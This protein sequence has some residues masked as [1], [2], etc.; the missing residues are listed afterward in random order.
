MS[1]ICL[2]TCAALDFR[3]VMPNSMQHKTCR[4]RNTNPLQ[5]SYQLPSATLASALNGC[6]NGAAVPEGHVFHIMRHPDWT[7]SRGPYPPGNQSKDIDGSS[8]RKGRPQVLVPA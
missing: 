2:V 8:A 4:P 1:V 5:P 3:E 6:A 7:F